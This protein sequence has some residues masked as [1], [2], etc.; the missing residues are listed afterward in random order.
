MPR[1]LTVT[2]TTVTALINSVLRPASDD[3]EPTGPG[4]PV[5]D[6]WQWVLLNPQP[7]PPRETWGPLPDPWRW[8]LAVR[9]ELA[10]TVD[11]FEQAGIIVVGGDVERA[12]EMTGRT[13]SRLVDDFCGTPPRPR[14]FPGPWGPRLGSEPLSGRSLM[15]AA[16]QFEQAAE[17]LGDHPLTGVLDD[18]A[19]RLFETGAERLG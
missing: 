7:L 15:V 11:Q 8:A 3:P 17:S 9:A 5:L 2:T 6:W 1:P 4:G 16:A 18:A 12:V 19:G 14:P 13:V 10:R